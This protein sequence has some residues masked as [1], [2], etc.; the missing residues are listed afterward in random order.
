[1]M[2]SIRDWIG[3]GLVSKAKEY[4]LGILTEVEGEVEERAQQRRRTSW[5]WQTSRSGRSRGVLGDILTPIDVTTISSSS[6]IA[7]IRGLR[8]YLVVSLLS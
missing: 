4:M 3:K 1:M 7:V 5:S 6:T 8:I 2:E